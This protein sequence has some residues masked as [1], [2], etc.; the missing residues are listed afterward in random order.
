M[1]KQSSIIKRSPKNNRILAIDF[2]RGFSVIAMIMVHTLWIH[3]QQNVQSDTFLGH[4]I[5]FVGRGTPVFLITMGVSF[6]ISRNQS[7][8]SAIKRGI[9]I[10]GVAYLMNFLKFLTPI[11]VGLMPDSFIT[12]YGWESPLNIEKYMYLLLTGDILQLAGISLVILGF[13][14]AYVKNKF[15]ILGLAIVIAFLSVELRDFQSGT[16]G[17]SYITQLLWSNGYW[18]YF[19]VFPWISFIL[20]GMFFGQWYIEM[21]YDQDKLFKRMFIGGII[22]ILVGAPLVFM[23]E[24]YHFNDFFH[25]GPGGVIYLA[26]WNFAVLSIFH[27]LLT[28]TKNNSVYRTFYYCSKNVT[29]L[30]VIQWVL[31]CWGMIFFGFQSMSE[32]ET[33][34][35][36]PLFMGLTFMVHFV[37]MRLKK[38]FRS[39]RDTFK[40]KISI[41]SQ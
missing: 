23:A 41:E 9:L 20:L 39:N 35:L 17:L 22:C 8:Q 7:I 26:G 30:Y 31:I 2:G 25:L 28:K 32:L 40:R 1:E 14:R 21:D 3:A 5:H 24:E 19:S 33:I 6:M 36:M 29:S 11:L 12:A 34:V 18:V 38:G 13:V 4:F 10:L 37:F 15:L 27:W 16:V